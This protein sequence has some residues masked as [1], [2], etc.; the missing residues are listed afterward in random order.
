MI[1]K[2]GFV[3]SDPHPGNIFVR[4]KIQDDG[5][6]DLEVVLLD[7][8]IYTDLKKDVRHSY[9]KLWR[10]MLTQNERKIKE[11]SRELGADF[12]ELF[13]SMIVGRKYEDVMDTSNSYKMKT[14][15]G[16]KN[17]EASKEAI[18]SYA[19]YYHKDIVE[20]LDLI[21]RELLLI[22]KTN[23]YL[24]AIDKRLG[25]PNNTYNIINNVT[26]NVYCNEMASLSHWD[27]YKELGQ[28]YI[29]KV[30]FALH[31]FKIKV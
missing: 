11:A 9:T 21:K 17:D 6:K 7:H 23:N 30:L 13:T 15:L 24:R 16:E 1:Y 2:E 19:I 14:R 28:Y 26:W 31:F 25:N 20:I 12:Y 4:P 5:T 18:K 22:L 3:H 8:G 29:L 27:Y 10:G